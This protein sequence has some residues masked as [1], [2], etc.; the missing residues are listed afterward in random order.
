MALK[1]DLPQISSY[2]LFVSPRRGSAAARVGQGATA[3]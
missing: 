3:A 2:L 1:L